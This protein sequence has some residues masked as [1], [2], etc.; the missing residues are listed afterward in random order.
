MSLRDII[1]PFYAWKRALEKPFT[2]KKP[3]DEREGP[4]R[5]RGFHVN[6]VDACVGCGTC[7]RI[8]QNGAIDMVSVEGRAPKHGDSALRPR[9]DYG[10][11]CWC[12]LCV[13][14]CPTG[15]LGM[16]NEYNWITTEGNDW[17]FTPGIDDKPWNGAV[18]GYRCEEGAR[19]LDPEKREMPVLDPAARRRTFDE[20]A[21]GYGDEEAREEAM[22]CIECGLCVEACPAH[23]DV[24]KYIRAVRDGRLDEGLRLLYDTNPF[25]ESCGRVCTARCQEA[26]PLGAR[27]E[28][29]MIRW[30]KR[31]ITDRTLDERGRILGLERVARPDTGKH[32]AVIGG[33][34]AGLTAAFYLRLLGHAVTVYEQNDRLGGMLRYGIPEYRL[35]DDVLDR[36]IAVIAG[37]GVETR[38]GVRVGEDTTLERLRAQCDALYI[39]VGA[40]QGSRMPIEGM[41]TPGVHIGIDFLERLAAGERPSLGARVAVLG[42]GN[43]AMDVSRS[44]VRLGSEQVKILYRRT[45]AEMPAS[46]E[47]IAEAREEG[48]AIEF[49]VTPTR[50]ARKAGTA[51]E[52]ECL[53]MQL[54]EPDASGRRRPVPIE[55]SE[56][57]VEVD[58]CIMAIGQQVQE[59]AGGDAGIRT[60]RWGT[61]EVDAGTLATSAPGVFAG[62]DCRRGPEDAIGAIADGGKAAYFIHRYLTGENDD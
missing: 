56:F 50:I 61:F 48:V 59:G 52:V 12:A 7:S 45:E 5:Y 42:G 24:P 35:P 2:I 57:T 31:Y 16:S 62:G 18:K 23:M 38:T 3:I 14:V 15:S 10:R 60:T 54:G 30:L 4:P 51:L 47:E 43:T 11:C 8:C 41:D 58:S 33:G 9:I 20:T 55:G 37:T 19:L 34:P 46:A 17:L 27:G 21:L 36:E 39:A 25:P 22:R 26:C 40:W 29:I 6:D 32:V 44:A 53:R 1:S 13:D 28:P 49:L